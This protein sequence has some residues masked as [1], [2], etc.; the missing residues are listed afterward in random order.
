VPYTEEK[1]PCVVGDVPFSSSKTSMGN[2]DVII[3]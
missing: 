2:N 3:A 1:A